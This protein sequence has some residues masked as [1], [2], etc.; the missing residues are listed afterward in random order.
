MFDSQSWFDILLSNTMMGIAVIAAIGI[1]AWSLRHALS[2]LFEDSERRWRHIARVWVWT[3]SALI[4]W[5]TLFDDWLQ[6]VTEP[7][8]LSQRWEYQRVIFDP[9][10]RDVRIVTVA[11]LIVSLVP[12]AALFARHIGGYLLQFSTLILAVFAWFPIFVFRQ[13]LDMF[14]NT[15]PESGNGS[16]AEIGGFLGF[17]VMRTGFGVLSVA[18]TWL[19]LVMTVAPIVTFVLDRLNW[20]QP[21]ISDEAIPFYAALAENAARHVDI[22]LSSRWRPIRPHA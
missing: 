7:Y 10:D 8:R 12:T 14:V 3:V 9:I 17:W 22:P 1:F 2:V 6:L 16:A 13:R 21:R 4:V 19:V 18:S 15:I 5:I 11:L 20:R